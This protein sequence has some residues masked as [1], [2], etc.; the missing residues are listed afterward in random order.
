MSEK[1]STVQWNPFVGR[2]V[3]SFGVPD[4]MT[5]VA[6]WSDGPAFSETGMAVVLGHTQIGGPAVFNNLGSL[7]I[8][9][10]VEIVDRG[11]SFRYR[12]SGHALRVPKTNPM[13]LAHV[14][15][16][17]RI[18]ADL[19]LITCDGP[20]DSTARAS[21]DNTIVFGEVIGPLQENADA[22]RMR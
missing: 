20:F 4:D 11:T 5:S 21:E 1:P 8:G 17:A 12:V 15:D 18:R 2:N 9:S 19:A 22:M 14:L 13:A 16:K 6:R 3:R 7:P 10:E